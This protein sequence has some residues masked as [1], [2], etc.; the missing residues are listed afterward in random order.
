MEES[1][2]G[3]GAIQFAGIVAAATPIILKLGEFLKSLGIDGKE[4][5]EVGKK[6]LGN[7][8]KNIVDR[9]LNAGEEIEQNSI[10]NINQIE[11]GSG[12]T[13]KNKMIIPIVLG[14][15]VLA[16]FLLKKK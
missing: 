13:T 8:V 9:K 5:L 7:Q 1:K 11:E 15:G 6:A 10:E 12:I 4:L 3:I 14:G 16:Y 2:H